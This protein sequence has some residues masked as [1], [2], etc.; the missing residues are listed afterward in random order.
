MRAIHFLGHQ[1]WGMAYS[2]V[3]HTYKVWDREKIYLIFLATDSTDQL[4][5]FEKSKCSFK[6]FPFDLADWV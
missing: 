2:S 5:K 1:D 4:I 6:F 3:D